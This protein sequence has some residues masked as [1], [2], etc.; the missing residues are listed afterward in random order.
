MDCLHWTQVMAQRLEEQ[1]IGKP[2][3]YNVIA[4]DT[5]QHPLGM[6][7]MSVVT[8]PIGTPHTYFS[9][10]HLYVVPEHRA[11]GIGAALIESTFRHVSR[12]FPTVTVVEVVAM[13]GDSQWAQ[14]G[15]IPVSTRYMSTVSHARSILAPSSEV[16][17]HGR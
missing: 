7:M 6:L 2:D 8:R 16:A 14:R 17:I 3:I 11:A 13:A 12:F 10:D 4:L 15:F 5:S 1:Q 9:V